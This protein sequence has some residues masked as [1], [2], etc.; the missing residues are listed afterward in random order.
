MPARE[1]Q[2]QLNILR[3]QLEQIHRCQPKSVKT[4]KPDAKIEA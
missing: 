3:E 1:L 2:E 4:W